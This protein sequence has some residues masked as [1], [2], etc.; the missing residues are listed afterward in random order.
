LDICHRSSHGRDAK[1]KPETLMLA[2]HYRNPVQIEFGLGAS[3]CLGEKIQDRPYCL[4]TYG[5]HPYFDELSQTIIETAGQP[6]VIFR[7]VEPEPGF[8]GLHKASVALSQSPVPPKVIVAVGGGSA[9]DTAKVLS[10]TGNDSARLQRYLEGRFLDDNSQCLP[11][12]AVPTTAGTGSE[13]TSWATVWD[14]TNKAKY[15]LSLPRLYP[16]HAVIDPQLTRS[17]PRPLTLSTGL[18]ALSHALESIWNVNANPVSSNYAVSAARTLIEYLPRVLEYPDDIELRARIAQASVFAGLAF[19]NTKTA[20]AHSLSYHLTLHCGTAHGIAC[21]FSLPAILRSV[22]GEN[23][24]CDETLSL[25]FGADL[26]RGADELENF[27]HQLGVSTRASDYGLSGDIW[28]T[29]IDAA[30]TGERGRN[31][32][33][34]RE[35]VLKAVA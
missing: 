19:S 20:I 6:A 35:A 22:I 1:F 2:W 30:F 13:V 34:C 5:D 7:E 15:S 9:I 21:S 32:I 11:I 29:V 31:F 10:A 3:Q 8:A 23:P 4:L 24:I 33:G 14:K 28:V 16:E 26:S 27:L 25:I 18:D 17:L 12:I